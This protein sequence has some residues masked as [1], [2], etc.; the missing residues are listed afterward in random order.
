MTGGNV[1]EPFHKMPRPIRATF[2]L[3]GIFMS[4]NLLSLN[5]TD[6]QL[7][8]VDNALTALEAA[9]PGLISLTADQRKGLARMGPKSEAFCRQTLTVLAQNPQ[10]IPPSIDLAEAQAGPGRAGAADSVPR[11]PTTHSAAMSWPSRWK[12]MRC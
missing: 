4:Q 1:P 10:V 7:L 12:A 2:H 11:T 6:E 3:K 5:F 8:A 9:L